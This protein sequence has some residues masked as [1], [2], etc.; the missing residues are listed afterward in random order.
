[1][2]LRIHAA[3]VIAKRRI[4]ETLISPGYYIALTIGLLLGYFLIAGFVDSIDSSGFS[5]QLN[6]VYNLI[7]RTLEGAFGTS[8]A[9]QL[10]AEGPF[11]FALIITFFPV[12][13]YLAISSVFRFGLEKKVGAI[14]LLAYGPADGTAYFMASMAKDI[15]ITL[16]SMAAVLVF[17][18]LAALINNL[19]LG[20]IVFYSLLV[21]FFFSLVVYAY[22]VLVST[23]V[24]NS[25]SAIALFLVVM[26]FF[27]IVMMGSFT[28]VSSYVRSLAGVF[29]W[30]T[31]WFS[32]LFYWGMA[33]GA[34]G[35]GK[36]GLFV[37]SLALFCVL[38]VGI[39]ALSHI[40]LRIKGVRA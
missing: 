18:M 33:L 35:T 26:A 11:L 15:L 4:F 29:S 9:M 21:I 30:I 12:F 1:M 34:I 10:F 6:P 13:I 28:I 22:G 19:L 38:T 23:L 36:A 32:P 40:V 20:P 2:N 37:L 14:E 7:G 8:F 27:L 39:L 16:V 17:L 24:D 25:A 3:K 5:F 31:Q